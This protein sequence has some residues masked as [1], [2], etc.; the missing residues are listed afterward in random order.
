MLAQAKPKT[1]KRTPAQIQAEAA[2]ELL[3]RKE[4]ESGALPIF[5]EYPNDPVGWIEK[6]FLIP[7]T[8]DHRTILEPYQKRCLRQALTRDAN[9]NFPYSLILWSD[10][11]KSIKS[12]IAAA[13]ALWMAW[14]TPWGSIKIVAN[15]LKQADSREAFYIRRAIE[16]H[17]QMREMVKVNLS[18]YTIRFPNHAVIEAIP[19]DP[20]G[21]AGGNDDM[22][23]FTEVWAANNDAAQKL[24]T[25][26]TI[27]PTKAGKSF[28]WVETYAGFTGK[29]PILER[30]WEDN[31]KDGERRGLQFPWA[32]E[33]SP[34]LEVFENRQSGIFALWNTTP[35]CSW[36]SDSY[37][38]SE[39]AVLL[40]SEFNRVHRNQWATASDAFVQPEWWD[41]CKGGMIPHDKNDPHFMAL[42]AAVDGDTFGLILI[43]GGN[44]EN[45]YIRYARRWK[46]IDGQHI[47]FSEVERE[48]IRLCEEYNVTEV[49]YDPYQL[50]DMSQRL[51]ND[52]VA[53][54]FQFSQGS[55]RLMADKLLRDTIIARRIHHDGDPVLREHV[56][57]ADAKTEGDKLR[58]V[59]RSQT[60]KI[61]LCVCLSM[62]VARAI[63]WRI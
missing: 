48:V 34:P 32:N 22:I 50:E 19:V 37:Y 31:V 29:S 52:S 42:D 60:M 45:Y 27:S 10:I 9:G 23:C 8:D 56:T 55:P 7:E 43:S 2:L 59:K 20:K 17:P 30:L 41:A 62:A 47:D 44:N 53:R 14:N 35:R 61:D 21:E 16:L 33:F 51:R 57:N 63:Y 13:V 38:N 36:Q 18:G 58:I 4:V 28:R 40:P 46:P 11:K 15:D 49:C 1:T 12:M 25:E 6:H 3:R 39:Q 54:M 5:R 26:L 24:W